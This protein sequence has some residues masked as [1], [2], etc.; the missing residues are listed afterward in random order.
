MKKTASPSEKNTASFT[1]KAD[2]HHTITAKTTKVGEKEPEVKEK[3][4]TK[5]IEGHREALEVEKKMWPLDIA[6]LF[7][8][9]KKTTEK[10]K[11]LGYNT[12]YDVAHEK[13]EKLEAL[14]KSYGTK[15]NKISLS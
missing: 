4:V 14:F 9:G 1:A 15:R 2:E 13:K 5:D 11:K 6:D 7:M 10:L 8:V 3:K 12:I